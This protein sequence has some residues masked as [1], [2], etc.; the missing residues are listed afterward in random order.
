VDGADQNTSLV[1]GWAMRSTAIEKSGAGAV[2]GSICVTAG[3]STVSD[4]PTLISSANG[5]RNFTDATTH[6]A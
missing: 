1:N 5:T 4:P 6:T 2:A 3:V